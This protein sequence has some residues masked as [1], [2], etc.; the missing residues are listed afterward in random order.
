MPYLP[1]VVLVEIERCPDSSVVLTFPVVQ[2]G[3]TQWNTG[4]GG[5]CGEGVEGCGDSEQVQ[6]VEPLLEQ[7]L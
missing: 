1:F 5:R 2:T 7:L 3:Q 4:G 6:T